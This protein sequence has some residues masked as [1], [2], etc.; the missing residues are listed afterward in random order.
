MAGLFGTMPR[1][2]MNQR[3]MHARP[4][5]YQP[6]YNP[7]PLIFSHEK[8]EER[9]DERHS[10][11]EGC[12]WEDRHPLMPGE[13]GWRMLQPLQRGWGKLHSYLVQTGLSQQ[14]HQVTHLFHPRK[15]PKVCVL[16]VL[17]VLGLGLTEIFG[18]DSN[19]LPPL[20]VWFWNI[21]MRFR[22]VHTTCQ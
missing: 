12:L 21:G 8:R 13:G 2:R 19:F 1:D 10:N 7:R 16:I 20:W 18:H 22:D 6:S 15:G 9:E 3:C 4:A 14:S 5:L 11:W 17:C